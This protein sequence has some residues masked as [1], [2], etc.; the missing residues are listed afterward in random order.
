MASARVANLGATDRELLVQ[1]DRALW[2]PR[3]PPPYAAQ[4][5]A[6]LQGAGPGNGRL[7]ISAVS[8]PYVTR[9]CGSSETQVLRRETGELALRL[10]LATPDVRELTAIAITAIHEVHRAIGEHALADCSRSLAAPRG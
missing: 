4:A 3:N 6:M 5:S 8:S 7:C 9:R 2:A 1:V 10:A